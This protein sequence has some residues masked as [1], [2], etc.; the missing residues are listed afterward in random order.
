LRRD[1][2][3]LEQA[4]GGMRVFPAEKDTFR[5]VAIRQECSQPG[6]QQRVDALGSD[7]EARDR[8]AEI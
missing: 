1:V 8:F 2:A 6:R 7:G 4:A 3:R 5:A